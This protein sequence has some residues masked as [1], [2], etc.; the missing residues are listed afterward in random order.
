MGTLDANGTKVVLRSIQIAAS[1]EQS[2]QVT[3]TLGLSA[4]IVNDPDI[5]PQTQ[6][7]GAGHA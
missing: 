4:Y 5:L 2:N 7:K 1:E 3:A 6:A